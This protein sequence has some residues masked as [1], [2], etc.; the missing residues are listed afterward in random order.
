MQRQKC[1]QWDCLN[2]CFDLLFKD[3]LNQLG[4]GNICRIILCLETKKTYMDNHI[5]RMKTFPYFLK[6][7]TKAWLSGP[8]MAF[9]NS[10]CTLTK[11]VAMQHLTNYVIQCAFPYAYG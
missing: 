9:K 3:V 1:G 7:S 6:L 8:K 11:I 2:K 5:V 10:I 4:I